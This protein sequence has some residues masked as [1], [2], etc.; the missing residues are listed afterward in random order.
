MNYRAIV[1][2][3][4]L[5]FC[6]HSSV[7]DQVRR[8]PVPVSHTLLRE[9]KT[10][11]PLERDSMSVLRQHVYLSS[12]VKLSYLEYLSSGEKRAGCADLVTTPSSTFFN[13]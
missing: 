4:L 11:A 9:K 8:E 5:L 7:V 12:S 6:L 13:V 2:S 3:S 10:I 1:I